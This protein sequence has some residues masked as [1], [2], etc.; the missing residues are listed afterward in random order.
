MTKPVTT[1]RLILRDYKDA[2]FDGVHAYAKD[3]ETVRIMTW[4]PNTSDDTLNFI[5]VAIF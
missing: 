5:R 1:S 2:D 3:P 4:G